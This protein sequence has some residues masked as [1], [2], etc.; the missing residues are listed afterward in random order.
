MDDKPF[1]K[2][3]GYKNSCSSE[4]LYPS[5]LTKISQDELKKIVS[6]AVLIKEKEC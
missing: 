3:K 4:V 5:D 2:P 1:I 6:N